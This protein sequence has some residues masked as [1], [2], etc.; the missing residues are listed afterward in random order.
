MSRKTI[1]GKPIYSVWPTEGTSK[2][3]ISHNWCDPCTW[4]QGGVRVVDE[5]AICQNTGSWTLYSVASGNVIDTYHGLLSNEDF[6]RDAQNNLYRVIVKVNGTASVEQDPHYGSGGGHTI[7][8]RNGR[9]TFL[10]ARQETDEVRVTYHYATYGTFTVKPDPGKK[11]KIKDVE[12]QFTEDIFLTD[13]VKFQPRGKVESFAPQYCPVPYPSGTLIPLGN[14]NVYKT[15]QDYINEANG[16]YPVISRM[17]FSGTADWRQLDK[18]TV[19]FPWKYQALKELL[20][21]MGM[22]VQILM[23]H[24]AAF[25][26]TSATATFYCFSEDE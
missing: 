6:L 11:L 15:M 16:A 17:N 20:S 10:S 7:D 14:P 22:E 21:S 13:T 2:N 5:V 23:E 24:N 25:S 18:A 3:I 26:G 8:Y 19:T 12:V 9:I 4:Y 1:D